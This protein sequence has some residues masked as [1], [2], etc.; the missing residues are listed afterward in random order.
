[1]MKTRSNIE[2]TNNTSTC[3]EWNIK[4]N[5]NELEIAMHRW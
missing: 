3:K 2:K 4:N 1:M 5:Q